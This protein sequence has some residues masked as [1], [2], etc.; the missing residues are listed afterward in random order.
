[1]RP[2]RLTISAFG[3]YADRQVLELDRLGSRGL[4]LITG[5]TGAGKTTIFDAIVFALYGEASGSVREPG[6]FRSK[7]AAPETPTEV[8]LVFTYGGKTYTVKRNPRYM[9]PKLRGDGE[10]EQKAGAQLTCPDGRILTKPVE[11]DDAVREIMGVDRN[12]FCQIAMIA[13][14]E[15]LELL[16]AKTQ[17][18][19]KIFR[20]IFG[21]ERY[22]KLQDKLKEAANELKRQSDEA[23]SSVRQYIRG[24]RCGEES[25]LSAGLDAAMEERLPLSEVMQLLEKILEEDAESYEAAGREI[26]SL[27]RELE[28]I[29]ARLG[30]A[31]QYDKIRK[32]LQRG[33][34]QLEQEQQ[35]LSQAEQAL[36]AER[37][38]QPERD[39]IDSK[40]TLFASELP[41][42]DV[43]E[44]KKKEAADREKLLQKDQK[45]LADGKKEQEKQTGELE[46][47]R[48]ERMT[49]E[50]AGEK[51]EKL[52]REKEKA[53]E[54]RKKL[55][56]LQEGMEDFETL[57]GQRE[58]KRQN[59]TQLSRQWQAAKQEYDGKYRAFLDGQA[60]ILAQELQAGQPCPVCGAME[61]PHPAQKA[62]KVPTESQLKKA[63]KTAEEARESAEKASGECAA[64]NAAVE[65]AR[66]TLEKQFNEVALETS[67]RE[68]CGETFRETLRRACQETAPAEKTENGSVKEESESVG[69][70][71][72]SGLLLSLHVE[73]EQEAERCR[74]E[75]ARCKA[76]I[77]AE[78]SNI[79][80]REELDTVLPEKETACE[81]AR[82]RL[83]ELEKKIAADDAAFRSSRQQAQALAQE[84]RFPG[85]AQAQAQIEECQKQKE[86]LRKSLETAE[87]RYNNCKEKVS[88][89]CGQTES[90]E[91]QLADACEIDALQEQEKK[92]RAVS[93]RAARAERKE[94][95]GARLDANRKAQS[96]IGDKSGELEDLE[97]RYRQVRALSDTAGGTMRDKEKIMLETYIQMTYFDRIIARANIRLMAMTGGQYELRRRQEPGSKQ[98]QSG[99]ELDVT[100]HYNGSV[101]SVATLSGGEAFKAS[102]AL[103]LGLSDEIQSCAGGIRL[104]TMF[105]DEGFGSLDGESL[106][107]AIKVLL[108]LADGERLVGIISHVGELKERIDRQIVVT[109]E[110]DG[111]SRAGVRV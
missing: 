78:E 10:A 36:E 76:E 16:L 87:K 95:I 6:M 83:A 75:I 30:K 106:D 79:R 59:Y 71:E 26:E 55:K 100:D 107:Q 97:E 33:R 27:D 25:V 80:R 82:Q 45:K 69:G 65:E 67:L 64:A 21:T 53:E 98:S 56:A 40:I 110:K 101:R 18:R 3:S 62:D 22:V 9:R 42:Y 58:E 105:V 24:I 37:A 96:N 77:R 8:E 15:F 57:V 74:S 109:K 49:L 63:Q 52:F 84:L 61:H 46:E 104:D 2:I 31:E 7:Y 94:S 13:Q 12:Q 111:S 70:A 102:L 39:E 99:L 103:A 48:K 51:K 85:K 11:V 81:T 54:Q 44:E 66:K 43:L 20:H 34:E 23:R 72:I 32:E 35:K 108:E 91:R 41:R 19:Q 38:K 29:N 14:G 90:Y 17:E 88:G 28:E 60:G 92:N 5:D 47:L 73:I 50:H 68:S 93:A 4:Y 89:L 86:A 1:M